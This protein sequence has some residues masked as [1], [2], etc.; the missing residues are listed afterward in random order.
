[1]SAP[2]ITVRMATGDDLDA[3]AE[4]YAVSFDDMQPRL[5]VEQFLRPPGSWALIALI[6]TGR[7]SIPAGF[8][9]ARNVV[10]EA[11]VFSIGVAPPQRRRGVGRALMDAVAGVAGVRGAR[12]IYLEVGVDNPGARALYGKV[13]YELVGRRPDYYRNQGGERVDALV[14]RQ[15]LEN[16]VTQEL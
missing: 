15:N 14:L 9:V 7:E 4:I 8:I 12:H 16:T 1:V 10:D 3:I 2:D 13:G 5:A 11:E 6:D